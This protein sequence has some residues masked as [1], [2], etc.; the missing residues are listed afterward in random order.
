MQQLHLPP[1]VFGTIDGHL[2]QA[3][4]QLHGNWSVIISW[5]R[6]CDQAGITVRID[7]TNGGNVHFCRV[8]DGHMLLEHIV[9]GWQEDDEVWQTDTRAVLDVRI[10]EEA[11][12]PVTC[13]GILPTFFCC[14]LN[15]VAKLTTT[16]DEQYD[17]SPV[18]YVGCE[19]QCQLK[20]LHCLVEINDV[21]VQAAAIQ[22]RLHKPEK[23]TKQY[24]YFFLGGGVWKI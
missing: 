23:K 20:M 16:A 8:S 13:V 21:M 17:A 7:H 15:E 22:V 6:V 14:G 12:L 2:E 3:T 1:F 11:A 18:R 5:N 9:K 10:G 19:V 4:V 24:I